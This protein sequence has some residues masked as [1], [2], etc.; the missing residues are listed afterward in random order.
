MTILCD[1]CGKDMC[2]KICAETYLHPIA[3]SILTMSPPSATTAPHLPEAPDHKSNDLALTPSQLHTFH[4]N[5]YLIIPN[6]LSKST[7]QTL[8][9]ETDTRLR[10]FSLADHPMTK[11]TTG[12]SST[13]TNNNNNKNPSF[14][15]S[16]HI[17]DTYFLTSSNKIRY[18]FEE[19]AIS[20][21]GTLKKPQHLSVNKIG[22]CLHEL[23]PNFK[24]ISLN[25][26]NAAI[27]RSLGFRD[28]RVLQSMIICKQPQIGGA[29]P[30][31]QDSTFLYTRLP[32]AV[33]AW[34]AMQDATRA[35]GCLS[36]SRGSHRWA[37][38]RKRFVRKREGGT[39]FEE[40]GEGEG[41]PEGMGRESITNGSGN[42]HSEGEGEGGEENYTVEEVPAGSLVLIHGNVL[43]KSEKNA[44]DKSRYIYTFHMIEGENEYDE[45]NWLQPEPEGF[46][47]LND[48]L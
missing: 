6:A 12:D 40:V 36:F 32:S 21:S 4:T 22:H 45:K 1:T 46:S 48:Y 13:T 30:A 8:L 14:K 39:G 2:N 27:A 9:A 24:S 41:F 11:F 38:I 25:R 5:G 44:S 3:S 16:G 10:T 37:P 42:G 20:P 35:N 15:T 47:R 26:R 7:L 19:D 17:G 33:G 28:P 23:S 31:H 18:F 29:V 43:H 34:Y